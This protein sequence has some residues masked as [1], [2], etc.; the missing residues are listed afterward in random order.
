MVY[1]I[2]VANRKVIARIAASVFLNGATMHPR[3][4]EVYVANGRSDTVSVIHTARRTKLADVPV[5]RGNPLTLAHHHG[6]SMR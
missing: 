1:A 6:G 2:E 3:G 5:G 4:H